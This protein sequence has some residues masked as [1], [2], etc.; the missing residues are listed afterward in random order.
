MSLRPLKS[1]VAGLSLLA[2][3]S[4]FAAPVE[5]YNFELTDIFS[6]GLAG[7]ATN[8]VYQIYVGANASVTRISYTVSL[9]AFAQSYLSQ[10]GL[11]F[12][13]TDGY[14]LALLPAASGQN[15][16]GT[17]TYTADVDLLAGGQAFN[18]GSDGLL[19]LEFF[20]TFDDFAGAD[21]AWN[22]GVIAFDVQGAAADVPEPATG[23]LMGAGFLVM[24]YAARRRRVRSAVV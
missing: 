10:I 1:L 20:E 9:T 19:R 14:G 4:V 6:N 24:G 23:M 5:T 15:F 22:A 17:A 8:E 3:T 7:N 11:Q 16:S 18:V 21:G 2:C 12:T 13:S